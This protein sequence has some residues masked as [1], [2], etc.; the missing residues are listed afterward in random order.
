[1]LYYGHMIAGMS[2]Y[3]FA[4]TIVSA[5]AQAQTEEPVAT[6]TTISV[7]PAPEPHDNK[8]PTPRVVCLE[9]A[10]GATATIPMHPKYRT[11]W[12]FP[13]RVGLVSVANKVEYRPVFEDPQQRKRVSIQPL[14][15]SSGT[16]MTAEILGARMAFRLIAAEPEQAVDLVLILPPGSKPGDN[17]P[18]GKHCPKKPKA[19]PNSPFL[20]AKLEEEEVLSPVT[21]RFRSNA[22]ELELRTGQRSLGQ[23][24]QWFNFI[25]HN[26]GQQ[27]YPA[28]GLT[29]GDGKSNANCPLSWRIEG[30]SLPV[31][32]QPGQSLRGALMAGSACQLRNGFVLQVPSTPGVVPAAFRWEDEPANKERITIRAQAI[33]GVLQLDDGIGESKTDWTTEAGLGVRVA[34]GLSKNLSLEGDIAFLRSGTAELGT[35]TWDDVTGDLERDTT[36]VRVLGGLVLQGGDTYVPFVRLALG[37]RI[38]SDDRQLTSG[39]KSESGLNAGLAISVQLGIDMWLGKKLTLGVA[40]EYGAH[41]AG[42]RIQSFEGRVHLG[43]AFKL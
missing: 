36:T 16:N 42:D 40:G 2:A 27:T 24:G 17:T 15:G 43:Y 20:D 37:P 11:T 23:R 33:G 28:M 22:H 5:T 41:L 8:V 31:D 19:D 6:T 32:L 34:Y 18:A 29:M 21:A 1:M 25:I 26:T 9:Y 38:F 30:P 13:E 4:A 14:P 10:D 12:H 39:A 7:K 35:V 3:F